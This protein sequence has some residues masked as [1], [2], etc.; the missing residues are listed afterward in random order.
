[1]ERKATAALVKKPNIRYQHHYYTG[2]FPD[3]VA[4]KMVDMIPPSS[5]D[6]MPAYWT[7]KSHD[8]FLSE[9]RQL[10]SVVWCKRN[11]YHLLILNGKFVLRCW[12]N[13][14][15]ARVELSQSLYSAINGKIVGVISSTSKH[16]AGYVSVRSLA[17][18]DIIME[19]MRSVYGVN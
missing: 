3:T 14:I 15:F 10:G 13:R 18:V 12:T 1:M 2:S 9:F 11:N 19:A 5:E 17:E 16:F 6:T 8:E 7:Y 4:K